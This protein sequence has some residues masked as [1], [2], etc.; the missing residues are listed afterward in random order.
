MAVRGGGGG[1][2]AGRPESVHEMHVLCIPFILIYCIIIMVMFFFKG[3]L[4]EVKHTS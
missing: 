4:H 1:G 3:I 2:R